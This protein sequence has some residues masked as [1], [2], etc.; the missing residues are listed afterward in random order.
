MVHFRVVQTI[1]KMN[2]S[3]PG[4]RNTNSKP[5]GELCVGA[6]HKSRRLFVPDMDEPYPLL[7]LAQS[8]K[9]SV[10]AIARQ[11]EHSVNA[12]RKEPF[13]KYIRRITHH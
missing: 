2:A 10:D 11:T 8:L 13:Y 6:G 9:D 7:L 3:P 5:A 4:G 1:Q 12:P